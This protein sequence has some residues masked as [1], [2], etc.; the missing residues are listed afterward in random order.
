VSVELET[1]TVGTHA[2]MIHVQHQRQCHMLS[3][4]DRDYEFLFLMLSDFILLSCPLL[5]HILCSGA[6]AVLQKHTPG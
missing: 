3:Q 2:V 6:M 1:E 4:D 5:Y